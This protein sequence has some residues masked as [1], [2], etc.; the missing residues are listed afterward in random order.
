MRTTSKWTDVRLHDAA[1]VMRS[2]AVDSVNGVGLTYDEHDV[3]ALQDAV[4]NVVPGSADLLI[5]LAGPFDTSAL[6]AAGTLSGSHTVLSGIVGGSTPLSLDIQVG[7]GAAWQAGDPQ[8]GMTASASD[9]L[10]CM[11]YSVDL[12]SMRYRATLKVIGG[13]VPAWGTSSEA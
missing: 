10:I 8:F 5:E 4:H 3:T 13:S 12:A 6:V 9:G 11:A 7:M 1:G 2:I